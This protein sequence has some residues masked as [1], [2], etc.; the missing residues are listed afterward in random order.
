MSQVIN[1]NINSLIA[2]NNLNKSQSSLQTSLT[3]LSSGLRI[4]SA[5][6]DAAGLAISSRFTTQINGLNTASRNANDGISLAQTTGG[7]LDE[8]TNNLQRIR[9][10][11]VQSANGTNSA[12]DRA[13][14]DSE[15]QQRLAEVDRTASQT[16]FNGLNV[17]DGTYGT[18]Q[19]QVGANAGQTISVTLSQGVKIGQIGQIATQTG[20]ATNAT[21]LS[22]TDTIQVG[23]GP[24][25]T[26]GASVAGTAAGQTVGSAYAKAAA[27][28]AA[29]VPGLTVT[30]QNNAAVTIAAVST[31]VGNVAG[32]YSLAVN[33][34]NIFSAR[35]VS[36]TGIT[37]QQITDAINAQSGT[38]G[39]SAAL[40][41]TSLLLSTTDGR[42]I[43]IDQTNTGAAAA[44]ATGGLSTAG[45]PVTSNGV[46]YAAA[47]VTALT[48]TAAANTNT[49]EGTLTFSANDNIQITS[50]A[51][52]NY[53]LATG[54]IAKDTTTLASVNVKTIA[55]ANDDIKRVD[56]ALASVSAVQAN[57]GAIQNRFTSAIATIQ[58]TSQNLTASRSRIQDADFAGETANL[59]RANIL[60]QAGISVL[61]QANSAPQSV[62]SLL[63]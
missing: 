60:Q 47:T 42:D 50:A 9:E 12:S 22:G 45:A 8:V 62:L 1:T 14:L 13:A 5:A 23:T 40:S 10:L 16:S 53:G 61:S 43:K 37:Q 59:S 19:F 34:T 28:T 51:I 57:L 35:D 15:V 41:G 63:K 36:T 49:T 27:V 18:S 48:T 46:S 52:A 54:T 30:A 55:G 32:T 26:I 56:S 24:V 39:V 29:G 11:A 3:R 6:D 4:N 38:T 17:L 58:S 7:A 25:T 2:Q 33:G 44:A 31:T 21:A 20:A